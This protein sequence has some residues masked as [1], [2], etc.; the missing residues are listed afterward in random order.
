MTVCLVASLP[1]VV[2][3]AADTRITL[4]HSGD[5]VHVHDGPLDLRVDVASLG[6]TVVMPYPY[7]KLRYLGGGWA[8]VAGEFASGTLVLDELRQAT[9]STFEQARDRLLQARTALEARARESTGV[10]PAQLRETVVLGAALN[11]GQGVWSLGL[12]PSDPRTK[13]SV[14]DYAVN[15][16][17]DVPIAVKE[18]AS[19]IFEAELLAAH[20]SQNAIGFVTAAARLIH[21]AAPFSASVSQRVQIGVTVTDPTGGH[22]AR[23]FDGSTIEVL[24]F[25]PFNFF[26]A[27]ESAA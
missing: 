5:Q 17:N 15:F 4:H 8:V 2:V 14:G 10:A 16:P 22:V 21:A 7:R 9:A 11:S 1:G 27:S 25:M 24:G 18:Q 23:Y 19:R 13:A 20:S 12:D 3:A 26:P 6:R